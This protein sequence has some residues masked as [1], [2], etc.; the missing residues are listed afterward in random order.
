M[1][2][3]GSTLAGYVIARYLNLIPQLMMFFIVVFVF[4]IVGQRLI[5]HVSSNARASAHLRRAERRE[6]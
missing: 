4:V 5:L 6:P 1:C 3:I 2:V